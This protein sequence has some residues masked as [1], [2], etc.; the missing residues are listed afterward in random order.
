VSFLEFLRE[1]RGNGWKVVG[2]AAGS[3]KQITAENL[4]RIEGPMIVVLGNEGEGLPQQIAD[5]CDFNC[6]IERKG[7]GG[8]S[9]DNLDSLNVSVAAGIIFFNATTTITAKQ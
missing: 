6:T 8:P 7:E 5:E 9:F 4:C 3:S 1:S 2:T